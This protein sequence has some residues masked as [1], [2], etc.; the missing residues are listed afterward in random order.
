RSRC[1][2]GRAETSDAGR[3][4]LRGHANFPGICSPS[5]SLLIPTGRGHLKS[6]ESSLKGGIFMY[7]YIIVGAGSAGCVLANRLTEDPS[8]HVLLIEAG[9]PDT[10][11]EI[12][13][14][15]DFAKLFQTPYDWAYMTE[16]QEQLHHRPLYWPRG[17]MLGGSSSM[18]IMVY[19]RG[20]AYDYNQ[21]RDSGNVGWGY[22]DVLP[23]FTKANHQQRV[24]PCI[25]E[26]LG[27][28]LSTTSALL[29]SFP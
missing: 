11:R 5:L 1:L 3:Q 22:T 15:I 21:W 26:P 20:N 13:I 18:N 6:A 28:S 9:G 14:P 10:K 7:D 4:I 2:A 17:K 29:I 19:I 24:H 23:Y 16:A 25:M 8:V 12:H 27:H